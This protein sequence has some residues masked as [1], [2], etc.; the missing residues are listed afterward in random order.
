MRFWVGL[1]NH[2]VVK[3]ELIDLENR[4]TK[5]ILQLLANLKSVKNKSFHDFQRMRSLKKDIENPCD[6]NAVLRSRIL[7]YEADMDC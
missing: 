5:D 3:T 4:I 2:Y 1:Q 7:L 6:E